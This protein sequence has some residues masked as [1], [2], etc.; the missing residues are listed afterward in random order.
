MFK[1]NTF[2]TLLLAYIGASHEFDFA[3]TMTEVHLKVV[4]IATISKMTST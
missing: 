3:E 4:F 2:F 1:R